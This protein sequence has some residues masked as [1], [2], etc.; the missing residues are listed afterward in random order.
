MPELILAS[1]SSWRRQML[2]DAGVFARGV[3]SGVDEDHRGV[4]DPVVLS[5][6]LA[7]RKA[8]AVADRFPDAWVLGAD[9]VV[10]DGRDR[11]RIWGKPKDPRDHLES[12]RSMRGRS[13]FLVTGWVLL[14]PGLRRV[15]HCETE[16][17]V[18]ADL[19][20]AELEAYVATG[21]G[22]GCAGGY[23]A[24]GKGAFLFERID[25]DWFNVLG[26]PLLD[27]MG[28]LRELGWRFTGEPS[29]G[30]SL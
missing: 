16:L 3:A 26:L 22:S 29:H 15:G 5:T 2:A 25:G 27:V 14:G 13:H 21:E 8:A 20:D 18:R 10:C 7:E 9:Q 19:T 28:A 30:G 17:Y 23:T 4:T 24:E 6:M 1:T 11:T 12:L